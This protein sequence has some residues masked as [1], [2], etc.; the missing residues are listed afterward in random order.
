MRQS[1][2]SLARNTG[3]N[4]SNM[5]TACRRARCTSSVSSVG[6]MWKT[7]DRLSSLASLS[8]MSFRN[9]SPRFFPAQ[10]RYASTVTRQSTSSALGAGKPSSRRADWLETEHIKLSSPLGVHAPLGGN[11]H[12]HC[13]AVTATAGRISPK[14]GFRWLTPRGARTFASFFVLGAYSATVWI[15]AA[16]GHVLH[17][18]WLILGGAAFVLGIVA[19]LF[20]LN[21]REEL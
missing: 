21:C 8:A 9:L 3:K 11:P 18:L 12:D 4:R 17:V 2:G 19:L 7:C 5:A 14:W 15:E 13:S 6:L 10:D 1:P 16:L 20:I